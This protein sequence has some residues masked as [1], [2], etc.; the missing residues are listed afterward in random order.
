MKVLLGIAF[1]FGLLLV[2]LAV[3]LILAI[4]FKWQITLT[5]G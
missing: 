2:A 5:E 1:G 4:V 3:F